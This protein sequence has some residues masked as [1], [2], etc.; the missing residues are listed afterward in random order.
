MLRQ[1]LS[2][3][4]AWRSKSIVT[5]A[6]TLSVTLKVEEDEGLGHDFRYKDEVKLVH[7]CTAVSTSWDFSITTF[8]FPLR[9]SCALNDGPGQRAGPALGVGATR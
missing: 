6:E 7:E 9:V 4:H 8:A 5:N 1:I 3:D 2:P